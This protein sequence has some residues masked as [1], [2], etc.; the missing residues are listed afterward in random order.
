MPTSLFSKRVNESSGLS[1]SDRDLLKRLAV[2]ERSMENREALCREGE[3]SMQCSLVLSGLLASYKI[4]SDREQI[5]AFHVPGDLPDLQTLYAP[6][7]DR[8]IVSIG[9]SRVGLIPHSDLRSMIE[10]SPSLAGVF[11][12]ETF[13]ETTVLR[14]WICNVGSRGALA[15]V[16]HLICEIAS[17]LEAVGLVKDGAFHLPLVQQD[18]A[19]ACGLSVVHVNR[20]V[21]ELRKRRLIAWEG[22][23]V[24]LLDFDELKRA[25]EFDPEYLHGRIG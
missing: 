18:I 19:N 1:P 3:I 22:R 16:A 9:N 8:F 6:T 12:R 25:A 24:K 15:S 10:V 23:T 5:L 2:T 17:R 4:V 20:I 14:Q 21:Q 13:T 11:W 7:Y